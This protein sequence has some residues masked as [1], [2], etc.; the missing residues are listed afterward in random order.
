LEQLPLHPG[1]LLDRLDHVHRNADRAGT[2][3]LP[4]SHRAREIG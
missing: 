4:R 1:Q 3:T 2:A